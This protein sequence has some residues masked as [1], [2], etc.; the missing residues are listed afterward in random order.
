MRSWVNKGNENGRES[1][2]GPGPGVVSSG[3][4]PLGYYLTN[5][6]FARW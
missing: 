1:Y 2:F 3:D 4:L 6:K 5:L